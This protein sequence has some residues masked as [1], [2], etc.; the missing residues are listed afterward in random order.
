MKYNYF[1]A[2]DVRED[3][4]GIYEWRIIELVDGRLRFV[5]YV[6]K[7]TRINRPKKQYTRNV[8]R[9]DSGR[10]YRK[11]KPDGFRC[12]HRE[13]LRAFQARVRIELHILENAER[14]WL[15][16]RERA[17]IDRRRSEGVKLLNGA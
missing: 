3:R 10:P 6:G 9:L 8:S 4:P 1:L 5:A 7:Y 17:W 14:A 13:L 2:P 11:A 16:A 12:V 15:D